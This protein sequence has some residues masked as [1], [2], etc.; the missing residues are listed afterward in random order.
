MRKKL[1]VL[2]L[3]IAP[4]ILGGCPSNPYEKVH[5]DYGTYQDESLRVINHAEMDEL[6]SNKRSFVIAISPEANNCLCWH[7]FKAILNDYIQNE[8]VLIYEINYKSFFDTAGNQLDTHGVE[9]HKSEETFAIFKEGKLAKQEIYNANNAMFKQKEKFKEYMDNNITMPNM[10]YIDL[11]DLKAISDSKQEAVIYFGRGNCPDCQYVEKNFF[12]TYKFAE[13]KR[14]Y[15]VDCETIGVREYQEG[16][17]ALTPES[18]ERWNQFKDMYGLSNK[19]NED[20]GYNTGY[21]PTFQLIKGNTGSYASDILSASVYFNDTVTM[22]NDAYTISD[23]FYSEE[24]LSKLQ[25]LDNVETKVLKG[26][27]LTRDEVSVNEYGGK[28]YVSFIKEKAAKYH[29]PLLKAF[30]DYA[31]EKSTFIL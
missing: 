11:I 13:N 16:T 3:L 31:L 19:Y 17:S 22:E 20:F 5:I 21:V 23:S 12:P 15:V 18:Q 10:Y 8:H 1:F 2:P 29:D 9:I 6:I 14:M 30:L 28:Y 24:R 26:K 25:Y 4:L 7:D 27:G